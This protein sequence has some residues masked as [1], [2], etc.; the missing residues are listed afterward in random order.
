M[1]FRKIATLAGVVIFGSLGDVC[2]KHGMAAFPNITLANWTV[3]FHAIFSPKVALGIGLLI[4]F[5]ACYLSSLSFADLTYVLPATSV[6][7]IGMALLAR[8]ILHEQVSP[9][10]WAGIV[11]I[12]VGVGFVAR[13]P[14]LTEPSPAANFPPIHGPSVGQGKA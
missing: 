11:L 12:A 9:L 1:S 2:L 14:S 7:Y 4:A 13:G 5:F 6:G 3:L 10:R 8:F